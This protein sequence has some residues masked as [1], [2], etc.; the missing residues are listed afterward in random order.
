MQRLATGGELMR[1][2]D[3][4]AI[5]VAVHPGTV[6]ATAALVRLA[7]AHRVA[8]AKLRELAR[9]HLAHLDMKRW[10]DIA[11]AIRVAVLA[12]ALDDARRQLA[13][14]TARAP[15]Q[16]P[17]MQL[18]SA[19]IAMYLGYWQAAYDDLRVTCAAPPAGYELPCYARI[20]TLAGGTGMALPGIGHLAFA[21][22]A[23]LHGHTP[24]PQHDL[25]ALADL[26]AGFAFALA[27][28]LLDVSRSCLGRERVVVS[29]TAAQ[30]W[31]RPTAIEVTGTQDRARIACV[32][33]A[34]AVHALPPA[35][36]ELASFTLPLDASVI[37]S[38]PAARRDEPVA[39]APPAPELPPQPIDP[40]VVAFAALRTG[41]IETRGVGAQGLVDLS[42]FDHLRLARTRWSASAT[43]RTRSA[44][45]R[46]RPASVRA[47]T[48]TWHPRRS[49][50]RFRRGS[51]SRCGARAARC[52][53]SRSCSRRRRCANN[54]A[55][56]V[57]RS[58]PACRR[59]SRARTCSSA[60]PSRIASAARPA[61]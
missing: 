5:D 25:E 53:A 6:A 52:G 36:V 58:A 55:S 8:A 1:G 54:T 35:P 13:V 19:D 50:F 39:E 7:V 20:A 2:L 38:A 15:K 47:S 16:H 51:A 43:R 46:S 44:C 33:D 9:A 57:T 26:D 61:S 12:G 56:A 59:A 42:R 28:E 21:T 27:R 30:A 31:G 34:I 49:S 37:A 40:D 10:E 3:H 24:D 32:R 60:Q 45:G 11:D 17:A 48:A 14:W 41:A 22:A 4:D 29:F 18:L 23:A